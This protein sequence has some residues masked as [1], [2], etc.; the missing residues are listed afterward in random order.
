MHRSKTYSSMSIMME[1][2]LLVILNGIIFMMLSLLISNLVI[3]TKII[4]WMKMKLKNV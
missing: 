2:I 3:K 1:T 4:H